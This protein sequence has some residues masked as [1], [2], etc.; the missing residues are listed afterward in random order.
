[1]TWV[2]HDIDATWNGSPC[3]SKNFPDTPSNPVSLNGDADLSR[4]SKAH[5][6]VLEPIGE[7]KDDEGARYFFCAPFIDRVKFSGVPELQKRRSPASSAQPKRACV[8]CR[9]EPSRPTGRPSSSSAHET[10][11]SWRG[12]CCW[13]GMFVV[14]FPSAPSN[15][16]L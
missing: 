15:L 6:A 4:S 11:A 2:H 8:P 5:P 3:H 12:A 10:R 14:A 1:M 16:R 13:V 9:A 7:H